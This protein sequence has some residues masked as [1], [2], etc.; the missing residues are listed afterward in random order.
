MV[1]VQYE[2]TTE[3]LT[4]TGAFASS[5]PELYRTWGPGQHRLGIGI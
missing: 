4:I 2:Q 5:E 1:H 3:F